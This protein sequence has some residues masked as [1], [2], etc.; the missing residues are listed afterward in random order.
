MNKIKKLLPF[1]ITGSAISL[2][3]LVSCKS[4]TTEEFAFEFNGIN[5][6]IEGQHSFT[7]KIQK[8]Q[9]V[10]FIVIPDADCF[11]SE[12]QQL[13]EGVEW[14][15][16][17]HS[18]TIYGM[19]KPYTVSV[20]AIPSSSYFEFN[21]DEIN[22]TATVISYIGTQTNVS[23]PKT[24]IKDDKTYT[25]TAIGDNVFKQKQDISL[26]DIPDSVLTIG[27]N[28]FE[29]CTD[30]EQINIANSVTTIGKQAFMGCQKLR[31]VTIPN[32][33][34]TIGEQAFK[35]CI[36]LFS[37]K[38][39]DSVTAIANETFHGCIALNEVT[40]PNQLISIGTKA[41]Q[42]DQQLKSIAIPDTT[43][44]ID[45][46]AFNGCVRLNSITFGKS[47]SKI[48]D[49]AFLECNKL[50]E[51]VFPSSLTQLGEKSFSSCD[52]LQSITFTNPTNDEIETVIGR[53][54]FSQCEKL[55]SVEFSN[56][57]T[58][59]GQLSFSGCS[60]LFSITIPNSVTLIDTAAF[61]HCETLA[62]VIIGDGVTTIG[63]NAFNDCSALAYVSIGKSVNTIGQGAFQSCDALTDYSGPST[64][65]GFKFA[66]D[67]TDW[68]MVNRATD[69]HL[70][71]T[72]TLIQCNDQ[73]VSLD[74][75]PD[76]SIKYAYNDANNTATVTGIEGEHASIYIPKSVTY[77]DKT[78]TVTQIG[79][80]A[81]QNNNDVKSVFLPNTITHIGDYAFERAESLE[82]INIPNSVTSLGK[83]VFRHTALTSVKLPNSLTSISERA[84]NS[85]GNL[86]SIVIPSSIKSI[87]SYALADCGK[88]TNTSGPQGCAGIQFD[89]MYW[90]FIGINRNSNWLELTDTDIVKC[91][92]F[93]IPYNSVPNANLKY[94]Y[95]ED[96][97][98]YVYEDSGSD[99]SI[100][101]MPKTVKHDDKVYTVTKVQTNGFA[102]HTNLAL[103][104][105]PDSITTF[106]QSAFSGC[107][108]LTSINIPT[109]VTKIEDTAFYYCSVLTNVYLQH[110]TPPTLGIT[111][112]GSCP[113]ELKFH[114]KQGTKD[115]YLAAE[116]WKEFAADDFI[117][118]LY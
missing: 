81:F 56:S 110:L 39:S 75:Q 2:A 94:Q 108:T 116:G 43:T 73:T 76:Q 72:A 92:D 13:P 32:S 62:S 112:F 84:F 103:I 45:S 16:A 65:P 96:Q 114:I 101:Y 20:S 82:S 77:N 106:G 107:S 79:S 95:N 51:L 64:T 38:I 102:D 26:V 33:V 74:L 111:V 27:N 22:S 3:P 67:A 54:S 9:F 61:I 12:T 55:S 86:V 85:C 80:A 48:G 52:E 93:N 29:N 66:G 17:E 31:N 88:L 113:P 83:Y 34:Q 46:D 105:L 63:T 28:A 98:A 21:Y 68:M 24:V 18:L 91:N 118:D 15:F 104:L 35:Q 109:S 87:G 4:N 69:W 1:F 41:F 71:T 11:L 44:T 97:T 78:Y 36:G 8:G 117:E 25:V 59:I 5:C 57:I 23:I 90:G 70:S 53:E 37:I 115:L 7:K 49:R 14:N 50:T 10:K 60:N 100:V 47:I 58:T 89:G 40:L 99:D 19:D 30:L 42:D 6:T